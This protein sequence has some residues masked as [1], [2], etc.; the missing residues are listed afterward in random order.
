MDIEQCRTDGDIVLRHAADLQKVMCLWERRLFGNF[1]IQEVN[2]FF[3]QVRREIAAKDEGLVVNQ[4][5]QV[6]GMGQILKIGNPDFLSFEVGCM[7]SLEKVIK[8]LKVAV[9][10]TQGA[11]CLKTAALAAVAKLAVWVNLHMFNGSTVPVESRDDF[12][13]KN[14][15]RRQMTAQRKIERVFQLRRS[16]E[17]GNGRAVG[18]MEEAAGIGQIFCHGRDIQSRAVQYLPVNDFGAIGGNQ[19]LH[20]KAH[21]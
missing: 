12:A 13:V 4:M 7:Y 21:S 9:Q 16:P 18:I 10:C 15:G 14:Q 8:M 3:L 2:I 11:L 20:G 5:Q 6:D 19:P 1:L 17:L